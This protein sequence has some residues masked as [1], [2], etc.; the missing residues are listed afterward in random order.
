MR[1]EYHPENGRKKFLGEMTFELIPERLVL[2]EI[3][4]GTAH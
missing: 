1:E 4:E 3:L 2:E